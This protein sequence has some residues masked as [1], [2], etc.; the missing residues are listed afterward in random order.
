MIVRVTK[1]IDSIRTATSLVGA[2]MAAKRELVAA[3]KSEQAARRLIDFALKQRERDRELQR[4][5][6]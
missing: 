3:G 2:V 5:A 4:G 6:L 1:A